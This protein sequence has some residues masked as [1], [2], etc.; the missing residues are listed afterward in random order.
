MAWIKKNVEV[1]GFEVE[2]LDRRNVLE[3]VH[4]HKNCLPQDEEYS[5]KISSHITKETLKE[6]PNLKLLCDRCGEEI[7]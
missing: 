2:E 1:L 6:N 4:Y 5:G 7:R 3:T